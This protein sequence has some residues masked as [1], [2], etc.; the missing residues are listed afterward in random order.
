MIL[1]RGHVTSWVLLFARL[2]IAACI[3]PAAIAHVSNISGLAL[4]YWMKGMP[5]PNAVAT[6]CVMAEVFGSLALVLGVAPRLTAAVIVG[7]LVV[8]TGTLHRFWDVVGAA[9]GAEQ[10]IFFANLA[11]V[12]GLGYYA[13]TG[14][15]EWSW[16]AFWARLRMPTEDVPHTPVPKQAKKP[17]RPRAPRAKRARA[18]QAELSEAA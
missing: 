7:S 13:V 2:T 17:A 12:A 3:L 14:P 15:G 10:A 4:A 8:T 18:E 6:A 16:R 9:R 1:R 5:V 11:I